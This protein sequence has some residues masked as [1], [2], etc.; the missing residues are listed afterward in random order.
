MQQLLIALLLLGHLTA[1]AQRQRVWLDT[2]MSAGKWFGDMDDALA[3]LYLLNDTT[4]DIAGISLVHGV[5]HADRVTR[6]LLLWYAPERNINVHI[7]ADSQREIGERTAAVNA[8]EHSLSAGKLNII[9]LGPATNIASLLQ[10]RPDLADSIASITF[11]AG[12]TAGKT[13]TPTGGKVR[14]SDYNFEHDTA[15]TRILLESK[16]PLVLAGYECAEQLMMRREHYAHLRKSA[17][18]G[19]RWLYRKLKRWENVWRT[20]FGVR[21]GFIP[22]DVATVEAALRPQD[23]NIRSITAG[24]SVAESDSRSIIKTHEK[25]YLTVF[26]YEDGRAVRFCEESPGELLGKLLISIERKEP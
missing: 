20:F 26:P 10:L 13:F 7:G 5:K 23:I 14:F 21:N 11:C 12:R 4:V 8:L 1:S 9:A 19:D 24:I 6:Q 3:L 25:P 18:K 17:H 16:V 15:A 22:F 2:D